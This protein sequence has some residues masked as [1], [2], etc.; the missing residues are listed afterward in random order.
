MLDSKSFEY[1]FHQ[2]RHEVTA[3]IREDL[4]RESISEHELYQVSAV[5]S[6]SIDLT[7]IASGK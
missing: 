7:G 4:L 3:S 1:L 2:L 6:A 5:A